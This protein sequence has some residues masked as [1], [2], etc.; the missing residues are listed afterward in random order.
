MLD[1]KKINK[2][3]KTVKKELKLLPDYNPDLKDINQ[4]TNKY[5]AIL[6]DI[7]WNLYGEPNF[8]N[9][10]MRKLDLSCISCDNEIV[11]GCN[12]SY[13]NIVL[14][15]TKVRNKCID[16]INLEGVDLSGYSLDD[17]S[18]VDANLTGT[19]VMVNL[20]LIRQY[21]TRT[22]LDGCY[23]L[24]DSISKKNIPLRVLEGAYIVNSFE[25]KNVKVLKK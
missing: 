12:F 16:Y 7:F 20:D 8:T 23:V 5:E 24:N 3:I 19:K 10:E 2:I 18:I 21:S 1:E 15:P 17:V 14:D 6:P 25:P 9:R 22:K 13:T 4:R 11:E